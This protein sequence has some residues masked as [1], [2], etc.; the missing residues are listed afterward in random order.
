MS[1]ERVWGPT[2]TL[3]VDGETGAV[4]GR[5]ATGNALDAVYQWTGEPDCW[6]CLGTWP[7]P[8]KAIVTAGW[9]PNSALYCLTAEGE[10]F[11]HKHSDGSWEAL[12]GPSGGLAG[13]LFGGPDQLLAT[14]TGP[15]PDVFR[16][17]DAEHAWNRIGGP[18]KCFVIGRSSDPE[19]KVQVYGLSPDSAPAAD[20]GVYQWSGNWYKRGGPAPAIFV[21]QSSL[22]ATNPDS[23]DLMWLSPTGW[24]HI[25]GPAKMFATDQVGHV[26][27]ISPDG[28]AVYAWDGTPNQWRRIGGPA[29]QIFAGWDKQL[30]A[31]NPQ[32]GELYHYLGSCSVS[33][34]LP[35]FAGT[36]FTEKMKHVAGKRHLAVVL[37]DAKRPAHP[38]PAKEEIESVL[39]G[40]RPSVRDWFHENS[41]GKM[42]LVNAG[43]LGWYEAPLDKQGDHY[44]DNGY[45]DAPTPEQR[46][47]LYHQ[48]KYQDGWL[49]GHPE[50]WADAIRRAAQDFAFDVFDTKKD[51]TLSP[52]E[53]GILLVFPQNNT[54]GYWRQTQG[55]QYPK[56]EPLVVQGVTIP[57]ITEWYAGYS[58][59]LATAAHELAHLLIHTGDMYFDGPWP[60]AAARYSNSDAAWTGAVHLSAPEKLK[61]G[62]LNYR[63]ATQPGTY[64]LKEVETT[65]DVLVL[66]SPNR[67]T[68]EYYLIENRWRGTSYDAGGPKIGDGIPMDGI[69][70]W[71]VIENPA[72]FNS[73]TPFP[74][75]GVKDEWSRLGIR[76]IRENGGT[77]WDD[78]KALFAKP[79]MAVSDYSSPARL[80][81][82][83]GEPS[84]F[85]IKLMNGCGP[86]VQLQVQLSNP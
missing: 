20:K 78:A 82:L 65:G 36:L 31:T 84:G 29:G 32:T 1:W 34:N 77:P 58:P 39:F 14:G 71:H 3:V 80:N 35:D 52:D 6:K 16:W 4:Y 13:N 85:R 61:L 63:V 40:P 25:G 47:P 67:G 43:V 81:W 48:K 9:K 18:G 49:Q 74:P 44:W 50:K 5:P 38:A 27:G 10:V 28:Q 46:D 15:S 86:E 7:K 8:L 23:G 75:T 69:A 45:P 64:V 70:V 12:G 76:M 21:S 68:D 54:D 59:D 57:V 72:V 73:V 55:K 33:A 37:W 24:K 22:Y 51:A 42:E 53:L 2:A 79:G 83:H 41:G 11:R 56:S 30:F 60:Y 17:D 62:W 19:F 26:Y 66:F